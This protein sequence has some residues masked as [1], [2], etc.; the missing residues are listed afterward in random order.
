VNYAIYDHH[1]KTSVP[2]R[3]D[4]VESSE[5]DRPAIKFEEVDDIPV[6]EHEI[7]GRR[8]QSFDVHEDGSPLLF[9]DE[10]ESEWQLEFPKLI[11]YRLTEN[12]QIQFQRLGEISDHLIEI[13][14][15]GFVLSFYLERKG[16]L[17]LHAAAIVRPGGA[18]AFLAF[19]KGGKTSLAA[20]FLKAGDSLLTDDILAVT[21]SDGH[22][23]GA[24]GYPQMRM[25]P[26]QAELLT[27][28]SEEYP[29]V[30]PTVTK[31]MVPIDAVGP[32]GFCAE[33]QPI[34]AMIVPQ[35]DESEDAPIKLERVSP[36]ESFKIVLGNGFIA[37]IAEASGL[38]KTRFA[39]ISDLVN[40]V[41][42]YRLT[43]PSGVQHLPRV[44]EE[45]LRH[46]DE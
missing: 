8:F 10:Y 30:L 17:A 42:I 4:L 34:R 44:R 43:Y 13:H 46:L 36:A 37:Q 24:S 16:I 1:L 3:N 28:R 41:P 7:V 27:G 21:T 25:W 29:T 12:G 35:R 2:I 9:I 5:G 31:R 38:V 19:N 26:E 22:P 40:K 32:G 6:P 15:L 33:S 45:I 14:L 18:I 23:T 39:A 11:R 20:S